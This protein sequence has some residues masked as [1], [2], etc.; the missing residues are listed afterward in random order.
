MTYTQKQAEPEVIEILRLLFRYAIHRINLQH[1]LFF[2]VLVTFD[3]G[4]AVTGAIMM[5]A[6]GIGAEYNFIIRYV[7]EN[8]GLAGLIA[9]KLWF[10]IIPLM[11]A[12]IV[13][14]QSYWLING[15]L[16]SL[17][18]AGTAAIQAN[19][20]SLMGVPFMD[21]TDITLLYIKML[22]ILGTAGSIIDDYIAKNAS[23]AVNT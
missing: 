10:I 16:A 18:M 23:S 6:K 4:D 12:S 15:I 3:I 9:V 21:P 11:I 14:K 5:D 2:L 22:V 20:Q 1:V 7:Y 19:L 13:N 8:H 17:I